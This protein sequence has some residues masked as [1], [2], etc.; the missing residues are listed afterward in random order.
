MSWDLKST[1]YMS[2]REKSMV[3]HDWELFLIAGLQFED[4]TKGLYNHLIQH[5]SFIA[6]YSRDGFYSHYFEIPDRALKFI[7]QFDRASGCISS[8]GGDDYWI[9][10]SDYRDINNSMVD[11]A[12]PH[13]SKLRAVLASQRMVDINYSIDSLEAERIACEKA[14]AE[15]YINSVRKLLEEEQ[16]NV[17]ADGCVCRIRE[18]FRG[19]DSLDDCVSHLRTGS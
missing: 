16:R 12:A 9:R 11:V 14:Y 19:G 3:L 17:T 10:L 4:F 5:C 18:S 2:A 15:C 13:L 7:S 1:M 6:H 8:E